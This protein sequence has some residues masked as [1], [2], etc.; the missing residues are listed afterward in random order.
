MNLKKKDPLKF[1]S[2]IKEY[3]LDNNLQEQVEWFNELQRK[4]EFSKLQN[5][6]FSFSCKPNQIVKTGKNT[7]TATPSVP[8]IEVQN[9]NLEFSPTPTQTPVTASVQPIPNDSQEKLKGFVNSVLTNIQKTAKVDNTSQDIVDLTDEFKQIQDQFPLDDDQSMDPVPIG[10]T[11][12]DDILDYVD[13]DE[14]VSQYKNN[15]CQQQLSDSASQGTK[16]EIQPKTV[17]T[18]KPVIPDKPRTTVTQNVP[19]HSLSELLS[20]KAKVN[21]QL[22]TIQEKLLS[23]LENFSEDNAEYKEELKTQR[24]LLRDQKNHIEALILQQENQ[25]Q[26]S[27][28]QQAMPP[29][30]PQYEHSIS[31]SISNKPPPLSNNS[32]EDFLD[33][34]DE[35][36]KREPKN[37]EWSRTDFPW[38]KEIF[39]ANRRIFGHHTFRQNQLEIINATMSRRDVFVLM[40]TGG[41][42]S[43]CF[44][45]PAVIDRGVTIVVSPLVSLIQDQVMSLRTIGVDT[46]F[47][48]R[49]QS[50]DQARAVMSELNRTHPTLKLLYLTP[51]K[52]VQSNATWRTIE[53]LHRKGNLARYAFSLEG[54]QQDCN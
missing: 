36:P 8:Q 46:N 39:T 50:E 38:S 14:M 42:K 51:E 13:V 11:N 49:G 48:G 10:N 21:D 44:Q 22:L 33:D 19:L 6:C 34:R 29:L 47:L 32:I 35:A 45:I 31:S 40:P 9:R 41:G 43:L 37:A 53:T 54:S 28:S 3:E 30:V 27:N 17:T 5:C 23:L 18:T 2:Q 26:T 15:K 16:P 12:M 25:T 1:S 52:L 7:F 4:N 24:D 20:M